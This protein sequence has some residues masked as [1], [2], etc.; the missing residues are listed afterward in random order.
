MKI[1]AEKS[2]A[3]SVK[4]STQPISVWLI[5]SKQV[6]CVAV[7]PSTK[8]SSRPKPANL[9]PNGRLNQTNS[10]QCYKRPDNLSLLANRLKGVAGAEGAEPIHYRL[11][12]PPMKL[13]IECLVG[14]AVGNSMRLQRRG[15]FHTARRRQKIW[16]CGR[17]RSD[18][19]DQIQWWL[20]L[21]RLDEVHRYL[22]EKNTIFYWAI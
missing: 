4:C 19:D 13:M 20:I 9:W 18:V 5:R 21:F 3:R 1:Y 14:T 22:K 16:V 7:K 17:D 11:Q 15:I 10:G 8:R 2:S 12:Y 6:W